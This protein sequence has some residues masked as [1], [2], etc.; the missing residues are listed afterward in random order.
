MESSCEDHEACEWVLGSTIYN[1]A[2]KK[3]YKKSLSKP[4]KRMIES[5]RGI[6]KSF[7]IQK[8]TTITVSAP[9][10]GSYIECLN[11]RLKLQAIYPE[12]WREEDHKEIS[13][14]ESFTIDMDFI[15][16]N[17]TQ[18]CIEYIYNLTAF[19]INDPSTSIGSHEIKH[20]LSIDSPKLDNDGNLMFDI[21]KTEFKHCEKYIIIRLECGENIYDN[22]G[23]E[24][25]FENMRNIKE[26]GGCR[27]SAYLN[28]SV[29]MKRVEEHFFKREWTPC[30]DSSGGLCKDLKDQ[31]DALAVYVGI[32]TAALIVLA[33][34]I[35]YFCE[36][37]LYIVSSFICS[38]LHH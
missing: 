28:N 32:P 14:D 4:L 24:I 17:H 18:N 12:Y 16:Y 25:S 23:L 35:G 10:D 34:I 5:S 13:L 3:F 20:L 22:P 15:T 37:I 9:K 2:T 33:S 30:F 26:S 19:N 1:C 36:Q 6:E 7:F 11:K 21:T 27:A 38:L 29:E 8:N 31:A